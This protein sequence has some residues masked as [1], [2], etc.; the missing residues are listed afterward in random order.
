MVRP[1]MGTRI[2]V[3]SEI[4]GSRSTTI[5]EPRDAAAAAIE[6]EVV[7]LPTPPLLLETAMMSVMI[8]G[9]HHR[10]EAVQFHVELM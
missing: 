3:V 4:E 6:K 1:V 7:V 9:G 10:H 2:C 5:T 8:P